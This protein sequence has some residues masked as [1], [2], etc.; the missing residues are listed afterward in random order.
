MHPFNKSCSFA[1]AS[2]RAGQGD[3]VGHAGGDLVAAG[4]EADGV[5]L[6]TSSC[7]GSFETVSNG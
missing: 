2:G 1:P 5:D 6:E 3:A 7:D 4:A